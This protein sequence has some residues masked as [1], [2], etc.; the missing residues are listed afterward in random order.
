MPEMNRPAFKKMQNK[1]HDIGFL[2]DN[3]INPH[4]I[5][6]D[7]FTDYH[8]QYG[9]ENSDPRWSAFMRS[10]IAAL[11]KCDAIILLEGWENSRGAKLEHHIASELG[12]LILKENE[13]K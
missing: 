10:D 9:V 5:A 13:L 2:P 11:V 12:L 8:H 7:G 6:H 3:V 4:E 1:L